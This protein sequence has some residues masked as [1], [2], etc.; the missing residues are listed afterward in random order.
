MIEPVLMLKGYA[1]ME[2]H[3]GAELGEFFVMLIQL[4]ED[5]GKPFL[6]RPAKIGEVLLNGLED[7]HND[8]VWLRHGTDSPFH[9]RFN[10]R[11]I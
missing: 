6:R 7:P 8:V 4:F 1:H 9:S 10:L 5:L 2:G 3:D 11:S